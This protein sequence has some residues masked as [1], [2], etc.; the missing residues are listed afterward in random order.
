MYTLNYPKVPFF[1]TYGQFAYSN[2]S[3][4]QKEAGM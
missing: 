2:L 4:S 3:I 1:T